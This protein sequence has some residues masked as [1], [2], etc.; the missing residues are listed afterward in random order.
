MGDYFSHWLKIGATSDAAKL[1]KIF[2]VNWFRKDENGKFVWPGFGDNSRVLAWIV[3]RLE[4]RGGAV[5]TPIGMVPS[6]AALDVSGLAISDAHLDLLLT[7]D[8]A[9]WA[10]EASL[11]PAHY[12]SFGSRLPAELNRQYAA[13]QARLAGATAAEAAQV[14]AE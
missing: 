11:I 7:V 10:E 9:V 4:G 3:D 14:A 8:K 13:L 5:E 1:P 12:A 2:F 6:K